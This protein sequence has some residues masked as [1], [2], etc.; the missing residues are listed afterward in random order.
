M[1]TASASEKRT[2]CFRRFAWAFFGSQVVL[3]YVYYTYYGETVNLGV[4]T[5]QRLALTRGGCGA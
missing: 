1:S 3:M 2:P 5:A 4:L